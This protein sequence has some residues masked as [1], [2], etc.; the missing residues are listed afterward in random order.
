MTRL[1]LDSEGVEGVFSEIIRVQ[2]FPRYKPWGK[3]WGCGEVMIYISPNCFRCSGSALWTRPAQNFPNS[4]VPH[5]LV[6]LQPQ[7]HQISRL[8]LA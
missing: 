7:K 4:L 5:P 2:G 1:Y 3:R 8:L 6:Q